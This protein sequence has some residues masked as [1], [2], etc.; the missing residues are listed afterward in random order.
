M[1]RFQ[2]L[3][4]CL[5]LFLI[6]PQFVRLLESWP[7]KSCCLPTSRGQLLSS[8]HISL[9]FCHS[10]WNEGGFCLSASLD[11][12][13]RVKTWGSL[14]SFL[15]LPW[16]VLGFLYSCAQGRTAYFSFYLQGQIQV[17]SPC[18]SLYPHPHPKLRSQERAGAS[19]SAGISSGSCSC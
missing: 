5:P 1:E 19:L 8:I 11:L 13:I 17:F 6:L 18:W 3:S 7:K 2:D 9:L 15:S 16:F 4:L 14:C 12:M 10:S